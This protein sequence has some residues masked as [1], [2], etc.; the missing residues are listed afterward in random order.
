MQVGTNF[1]CRCAGSSFVE[2]G[3]KA[4]AEGGEAGRAEAW[5][6]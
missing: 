3:R 1:R 5:N 4:L 6:I 2:F